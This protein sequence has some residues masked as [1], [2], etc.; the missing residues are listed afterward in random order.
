MCNGGLRFLCELLAGNGINVAK[1]YAFGFV[2]V[3]KCFLPKS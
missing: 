3:T 1:R 2:A